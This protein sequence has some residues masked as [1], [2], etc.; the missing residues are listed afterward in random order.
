M[1]L[2]N[3]ELHVEDGVQIMPMALP[4][5]LLNKAPHFYTFF[6]HLSLPFCRAT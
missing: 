6:D 4:F 1:M 2:S 3:L 5:T